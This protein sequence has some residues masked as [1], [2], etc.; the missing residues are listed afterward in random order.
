MGVEAWWRWFDI[1]L[2]AALACLWLAA[3]WGFARQDPSRAWRRT[4]F[5]LAVVVVLGVLPTAYHLAHPLVPWRGFFRVTTELSNAAFA[6][7]FLAERRWF[8]AQAW[9]VPMTAFAQALRW[10][11][12]GLESIALA[13]FPTQLVTP[14]ILLETTAELVLGAAFLFATL[15]TLGRAQHLATN[16][17]DAADAAAVTSG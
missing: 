13:A 3:A 10:S 17:Q 7:G 8:R 16:G 15:A 14:Q 9:L 1:A 12:T 11:A 6:L 5:C 2:E 4:G